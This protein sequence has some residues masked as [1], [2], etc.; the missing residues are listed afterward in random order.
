MTSGEKQSAEPEVQQPT[1]RLY[2]ALM[3]LQNFPVGTKLPFTSLVMG[4]FLGAK[5]I[6]AQSLDSFYTKAALWWIFTVVRHLVICVWNDMCDRNI[7]RLVERTK[8]RPLASGKITMQGATRL[9]LVLLFLTLWSM[10]I[11]CGDTNLFLLGLAGTAAFDMPYPFMKR[12]TNL[13]QLCLGA[14]VAWPI[15]LAWISVTGGSYDAVTLIALGLAF[16]GSTFILDTIY[17]CQD[18]PDDVKVGVKSA[19]VL[20]GAHIRGILSTLAAIVVTG[21]FVVGIVNELGLFYFVV[22]VGGVAS[23]YAWQMWTTDSATMTSVG[24]HLRN[25]INVAVWVGTFGDYVLRT[26]F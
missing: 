11:A 16:G 5:S 23:V 20:F 3:R 12:W 22:T 18:R 17:A 10:K 9:L 2:Y 4:M 6:H 8:D 15:P 7:D 26:A 14:T 24:R 25:R 21:F 13:P 1:W 19:A